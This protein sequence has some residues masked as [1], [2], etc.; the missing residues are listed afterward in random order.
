VRR[1]ATEAPM[2]HDGAAAG[3]ED[4]GCSQISAL[5]FGR[6]YRGGSL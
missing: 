5:N 1:E 3:D 6:E 4:R 2:Q